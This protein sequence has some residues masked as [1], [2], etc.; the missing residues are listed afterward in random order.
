MGFFKKLVG[1][2]APIVGGIVGGPAG[3]AAGSALGGALATDDAQNFASAEAAASRGFTERQLKHRHQWEVQDLRDAGLNPILSAMKGA[4]SIGGSAQAVS[5][6]NAAQDAAS[7]TS[8][9]AQL[10]QQRLNTRKVN[11]EIDLL[12]S[13]ARNQNSQARN[14]QNVANVSQNLGNISS[15]LHGLTDSA[16][17][18]I[19]SNFEELKNLP[20]LL[21]DAIKK[22]KAEG[23]YSLDRFK[24]WKR[25]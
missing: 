22:N 25:K 9:A 10:Q 3:A 20:Q 4:P 21:R 8:S 5:N 17:K 14:T 11:A 7:L 19:S 12:K 6:A 23:K 18:K 2:A 13:Q 1:A 24:F 16:A 15:G